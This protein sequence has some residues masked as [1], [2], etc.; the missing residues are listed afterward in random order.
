[1]LCHELASDRVGFGCVAHTSLACPNSA[2]AGLACSPLFSCTSSVCQQSSLLLLYIAMCR[3]PTWLVPPICGISAH[4]TASELIQGRGIQHSSWMA[5]SRKKQTH[6]VR[7]RDN[8]SSEAAH[9]RI[10]TYRTRPPASTKLLIQPPISHASL[11]HRFST[12]TTQP[13]IN[14]STLTGCPNWL[15]A[16]HITPLWHDSR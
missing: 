14:N 3:A 10:W 12:A 11:R 15:A 4:R 2:S 5:C 7:N 6:Q 9:Q 1:V 13:C 8:S 16:A